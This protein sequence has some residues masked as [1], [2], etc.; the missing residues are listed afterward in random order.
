MKIFSILGALLLCAVSFNTFAQFESSKEVYSSPKL[1]A[2]IPK[3]KTVAILPFS[4]TI[5]YKRPPKNYDENAH[6]AEEKALTTDLQ[7]SMYTFLLRKG[8][9]Y[10]CTFQDVERTNALLKKA[11]V[12]DRLDEMTQDSVCQI[13]GV[14]AVIK[15]KYAYEKTASEGAAI[16]KTVL[17][18]SLGS[19]TGSGGLTMQIYN[20]TD[21]DLLWR[22]YKAMND[23]VMS[24]TDELIE[25]MMR[26][27]ARNFPYDK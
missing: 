3:H 14:D 22:F 27:V 10:S 11:G 4:A 23:D 26:K 5:T 15:A 12:Y 2:E 20:G 9:K 24:S 1:N 13:L 7:S 17:F 19:K 18:G 16:A 21:G 25:R 8:G 6:K